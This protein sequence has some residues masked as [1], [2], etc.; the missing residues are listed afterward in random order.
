MKHI[1]LLIT[2][3][4]LFVGCT[5]TSTSPKIPQI[6]TVESFTASID[7]LVP[8]GGLN[9]N[10]TESN[11]NGTVSSEAEITVIDAKGLKKGIAAKQKMAL[12]IA[13]I[14][15]KNISNKKEYTQF[16]VTFVFQDGSFTETQRLVFTSKQLK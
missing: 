8:N 13:K 9:V 7:S 2:L 3:L 5:Y 10:G 4:S 15:Y 16:Y 14:F 1:I 12:N 11:V 6:D